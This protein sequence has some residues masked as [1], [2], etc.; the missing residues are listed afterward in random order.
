[1][2]KKR[3]EE[4]RLFFT[5]PL[6]DHIKEINASFKSASNPLEQI[7]K[8]VKSKVGDFRR[9]EA[10]RIEKEQEKLRKKAAEMKTEKKQDEYNNKAEEMKQETKV[11]SESGSLR[12]RKV[13]KFELINADEIPREY[14]MVNE[15]A[16]RRAIADGVRQI[17]GVR[18]Y[19]D[20]SVG[21]Y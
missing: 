5:K 21:V 2:R 12:V 16:I 6:N 10:A 14:L 7:E 1:M 9:A 4:L 18:I 13:W 20:E 19:E 8:D 17:N 11:E 15:T 3:I